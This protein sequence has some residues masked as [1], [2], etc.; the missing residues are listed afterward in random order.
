METLLCMAPPAERP[1]APD[2]TVLTE[3][4]HDGKTGLFIL[5]AVGGWPEGRPDLG[6]HYD[7]VP[8]PERPLAAV[9]E[10]LAASEAV[11]SEGDERLAAL[12]AARD[13]V[14]GLA[15]SSAADLRLAEVRA[16]MDEE[17]EISVLSGYVPAEEQ[18]AVQSAAVAH[19]WGVLLDDPQP[20]EDVPIQL[21]QSRWV[22]PVR[23]VFDFLN[24]YPGYWEWDVGWVFLPFF[25]LFFAMIVGDAGY[26]MLLL[27]LTAVLQWRLKKVPS[28]VFHMMY[29]VGRRDARL[30]RAHGQL[31]RHPDA[32]PVRGV[33]PG[34]M[35]GQ[36]RQPH[37]PVLPHRR[38]PPHDRARVERGVVRREEDLE[39][40]PGSG[41]L[42]HLHLVHVLPRPAG[43]AGTVHAR[44]SCS[45]CWASAFFWWCCS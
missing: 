1:A 40:G 14:A 3:L 8:W 43:R 31:L 2:G 37:R 4:G 15:G 42:A 23:V 9:R 18:E 41:G 20:G 32:A 5:T 13:D 7:V 22:R 12:A 19:G 33:P 36:P 29:I 10:E 27:I 24:I 35:A 11:R 6:C 30:G 26:A 45:T 25:S 38:R 17:G 21:R 16:G 39:Q 34:G 28:N 44:V